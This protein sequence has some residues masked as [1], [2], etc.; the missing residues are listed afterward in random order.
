ME[1]LVTFQPDLWP[2]TRQLVCV[3]GSRA[4]QPPIR[5]LFYLSFFWGE[6]DE[7]KR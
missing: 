4:V 6:V 3:H 1:D 2:V 5:G 7:K